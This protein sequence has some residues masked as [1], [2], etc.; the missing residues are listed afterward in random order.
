[1]RHSEGKAARRRQVVSA[2]SLNR[3]SNEGSDNGAYDYRMMS[4]IIKDI[5]EP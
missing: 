4:M 3:N 5:A 1:V 2:Q